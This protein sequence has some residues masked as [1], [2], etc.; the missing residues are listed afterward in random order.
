MPERVTRNVAAEV[1]GPVVQAGRIETLTIHQAVP[2]PCP[3]PHADEDPW[4]AR[5]RGSAV[6]RHVPRTRDAAVHR[7]AAGA[8]AAALAR[9]RD[10]AEA[11]LAA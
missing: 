2:G 7:D 3:H 11:R 8:V 10:E 5:V 4:A 1:T 6:W 9:L